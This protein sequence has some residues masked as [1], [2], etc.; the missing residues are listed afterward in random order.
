VCDVVM[1]SGGCVAGEEWVE[2]HLA[3]GFQLHLHAGGKHVLLRLQYSTTPRNRNRVNR[4]H[5]DICLRSSQKNRKPLTWVLVALTVC[6]T[7]PEAP[8]LG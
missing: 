2:G 4:N 6:F 1:R 7:Y 3:E 8:S 5:L